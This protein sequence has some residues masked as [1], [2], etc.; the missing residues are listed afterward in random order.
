MSG[1]ETG[2]E[3]A[4]ERG[5]G[6]EG[7][8]SEGFHFL[9]VHITSPLPELNYR[10]D[11]RRGNFIMSYRCLHWEDEGR[12]GVLSFNVTCS[13]FIQNKQNEKQSD[14]G[15]HYGLIINVRRRV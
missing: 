1:C 7:Q 10:I 12:R 3:R 9:C 11:T 4:G 15:F 6:T 8:A 14:F 5:G 2:R 13:A